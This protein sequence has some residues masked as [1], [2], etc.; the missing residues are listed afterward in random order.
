MLKK[1]NIQKEKNKN[2]LL[3]AGFTMVELLV[4]LFIVSFALGAI[5]SIFFSQ[6]RI[7]KAQDQVATMQQNLRAVMHMM[8]KEIRM[9]GFDPDRN[10]GG[11]FGISD[12]TFRGTNGN[13]DNNLQYSSITFSAGDY[14]GNGARTIRYIIHN[15][16]SNNTLEL[17]RQVNPAGNPT[18]NDIMA[19]NIE[20]FSIAYA[21]D[22]DEDD[23]LDTAGGEV[24]WAIDSNNDNLLDLNL[25]ADNDGDIDANDIAAGGT[26]LGST[27][28]PERISAVRI[29]ILGKVEMADG[30]YSDTSSYVV[31]NRIVQ[32]NDGHR[33]RILESV[34][35]CRNMLY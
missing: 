22:D 6:D 21:F 2:A 9:A 4:T 24:I 26:A 32:A 13:I 23:A 17:A 14:D 10:T 25:D 5:G 16:P 28:D 30:N 7:H 8:A 20:A 27:V 11:S 35:K 19:E 3:S 31:G 12:V 1:V 34:V 33:R 18:D 29:W 15:G